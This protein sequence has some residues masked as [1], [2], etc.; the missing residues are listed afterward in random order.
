MDGCAINAAPPPSLPYSVRS[1]ENAPVAVPIAWEGLLAMKNAKPYNID[2]INDPIQ[3]AQRKKLS[4]WGF[5][6][7]TWPDI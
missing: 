3:R 2:N 6:E 1:R 5:A 7:Q 4:G